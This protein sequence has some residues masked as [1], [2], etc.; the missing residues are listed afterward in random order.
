MAVTVDNEVATNSRT[1]HTLN[2]SPYIMKKRKMKIY[3]VILIFSILGCSPILEKSKTLQD[4]QKLTDRNDYSAS[5]SLL[6]KLI[7]QYPDFDSAYVERGFAKT[8][9]ENYELAIIDF[10]K[11]IEINPLNLGAIFSR[12][13]AF[14]C[15][16]DFNSA[17]KDYNHIVR[18]GSSDYY[19][20]ALTERAIILEFWGRYDEMI[21][22]YSEILKSDSSNCEILTRLGAVLY[23]GK[24]D[25]NQSLV[26]L[27][28]AIINCPDYS[29]CYFQ[30]GKLFSDPMNNS[31]DYNKSLIDFNR[32]IELNPG[33]DNYYLS[34]G[35]VYRDLN[36]IDSAMKDIDYAINLNDKNGYAYLNR[37]YIKE[38]NLNN[39]K[40]A[41]LDYKKARELGIK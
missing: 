24:K 19:L 28:Q 4:A 31:H 23:S 17:Y 25:F 1:L 9:I 12:A 3:I 8:K 13:S 40:A 38:Q 21:N 14:G 35:L 33:N 22:D 5:I 30:R 16:Q 20:Y 27:N 32:A 15:L 41:E 11:A 18:L 26:Y 34:R 6:N 2:V 29:E 39:K 7:K 36:Q 10:N 37:G